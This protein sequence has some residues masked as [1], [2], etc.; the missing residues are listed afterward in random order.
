MTPWL[1]DLADLIARKERGVSIA[2]ASAR[3]SVPRDAGTRMLVT[4]S[5]A[6][7]TIGGGH[8]EFRAVQIAREVLQGE[9][10]V[11]L[12][13]FP[14]GASLGQCCGGLVNLLFEPIEASSAQ[15]V[16]ALF[17]AQQSGQ[18]ATI[19]TAT[20]GIAHAG[21]MVVM[22]DST[23]GSLGETKIDK[24]AIMLSRV[25]VCD[26]G[27]ACLKTINGHEYLF[28]R[29][30][31]VAFNVAL[32][33]AGHVARALV[34]LLGALPCTVR[35]IDSRANEFP[36]SIPRNVH[37]VIAPFPADEVEDLPR[38]AMTL[39]M[40]HDH[41][42]DQT[43]CE[44]VLK[45]NDFAY[46][47]LIGSE[48]KRRLFEKRL[49]ARGMT[50]AMLAQMHCPIGFGR[51]RIQSKEPMAI[52]IAVAAEILQVVERVQFRDHKFPRTKDETQALERS[53]SQKDAERRAR[54]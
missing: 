34:M 32:F 12:H 38:G 43:I 25:G 15:W 5:R 7:G 37:A 18:S 10:Q 23:C 27:L 20:H 41:A 17:M 19:V 46:F 44:A 6:V 30:D 16:D 47:G 8:L 3:G 22:G 29:V 42:L 26:G 48:T 50:E 4:A 9:T 1:H 45:R 49:L 28:E 33:G 54:A 24:Q 35:W 40:T 36:P 31:P 52:A 53:S 39:V 2:I 51:V 14:L 11:S 13:R 21:K